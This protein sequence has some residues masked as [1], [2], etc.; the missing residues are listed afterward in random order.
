MHRQQHMLVVLDDDDGDGGRRKP[1]TALRSH[2]RDLILGVRRTPVAMVLSV[3]RNHKAYWGRGEGGGRGYG[4]V[5]RGSVYTY[6]YTVTTRM[7]SALRWAAMRAILM[8][9]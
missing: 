9:H 2:A 5:G 1:L 6:R 7:T 8:F 3:H 4:D